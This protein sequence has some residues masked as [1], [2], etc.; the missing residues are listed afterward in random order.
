M[1]YDVTETL[2]AAQA[3]ISLYGYKKADTNQWGG[4]EDPGV[5]S[6]K[7][8]VRYVIDDRLYSSVID[9]TH[10]SMYGVQQSAKALLAVLNSIK[11]AMEEHRDEYTAKA[12]EIK[13]FYKN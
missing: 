3:A 12:K 5:E 9:D 6:T 7:E 2:I 1:L 11:N 13:E 10:S 4:T 8:R